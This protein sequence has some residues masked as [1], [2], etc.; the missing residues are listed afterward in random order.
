MVMGIGYAIFSTK[1][2]SDTKKAILQNPTAN[3]KILVAHTVRESTSKF[4]DLGNSWAIIRQVI[5]DTIVIQF[6]ADK[7]PLED[8]NDAKAP[9]TGYNGKIYKIKKSKFQTKERVT[10]YHKEKHLGLND[11]FIWALQKE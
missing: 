5:G 11:A 8:L 2:I 7:I 4:N 10:E 9:T 1:A 3:N 6:H